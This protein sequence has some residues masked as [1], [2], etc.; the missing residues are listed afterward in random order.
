MFIFVSFNP[1]PEKGKMTTKE[2]TMN[3]IVHFEIPYEDEA[4]AR[5]FYSIFDWDLQAI[6]GMDYIGVTTTPVNEKHIPKNPGSI[7]GGM[8]KRTSTVRSPVIAVQVDSVDIYLNKVT[9]KG[10]K[11]VTPKIEIPNIGYY[12]YVADLEGNIIGLWE[13]MQ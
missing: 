5:E 1:S 6:P 7:N 12:A 10:G 13:P 11:I 3:P 9:E 4:K 2:K 8:M